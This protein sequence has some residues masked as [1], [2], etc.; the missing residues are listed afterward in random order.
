MT[1]T[2][3]GVQYGTT[4]VDQGFMPI[5]ESYMESV[6]KDHI[7]LLEIGIDKGDSLR[8]WRSYF[9]NGTICAIEK[10]VKCEVEGCHIFDADAANLGGLP[11]TLVKNLK[12][13]PFDFII[14]DASHVASEQMAAL[15]SLFPILKPGGY[16][17]IEDLFTLYDSDWSELNHGH[18]N[19]VEMLYSRMR[20]ILTKG[21]EI[22]EVHFYGRN[23][24]NGIVFLRKR[25]EL[26]IA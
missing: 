21:D 17:I 22:Q 16:Y 24:I 8:M 25:N 5:Y 14:D 11:L 6:R 13:G 3:L 26:F 1:L 12:L 7:A 9:P 18:F 4:K 20:D 15:E 10:H 2:E 19:V 23:K